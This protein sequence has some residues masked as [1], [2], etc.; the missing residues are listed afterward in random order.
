MR[1]GFYSV[2]ET[3]EFS[4]SSREGTLTSIDDPPL[5]SVYDPA[6]I[7][8]FVEGATTMAF[9]WVLEVDFRS[10]KGLRQKGPHFELYAG[11]NPGVW[12]WSYAHIGGELSHTIELFKETRLLHLRGSYEGVEGDAPFSTL[13]QLG[14]S[15]RLRGYVEGRYRD[16]HSALTSVEY[17]YPIHKNVSGSLFVD[18]GYVAREIDELATFDEWKLGA[19]GGFLIGSPESISLRVQ[20]AY[21]ESLEVFVGTDLARSLDGFLERP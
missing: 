19:G 14:G 12:D 13:P 1:T 2:F 20:I 15:N 18:A 6:T 4:P 3:N 7:P 11:G 16:Q 9:F 5:E 8:G 17:I 21:G 10:S